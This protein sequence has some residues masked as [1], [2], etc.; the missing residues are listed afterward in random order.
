MHIARRDALDLVVNRLQ[1]WKK[2][3]NTK[4]AESAA[5]L[6]LEKVQGHVGSL[7]EESVKVDGTVMSGRWLGHAGQSTKILPAR[8]H[9]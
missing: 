3:L 4:S 9:H 5:A 6:E 8:R 7:N 2:L 1:V